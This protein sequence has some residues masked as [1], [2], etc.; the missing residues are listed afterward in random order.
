MNQD[1]RNSL[2][3]YFYLSFEQNKHGLDDIIK[4]IY[5]YYL[6]ER[7]DKVPMRNS[8]Y[9]SYILCFEII[10]SFFCDYEWHKVYDIL[11][12]IFEGTKS[13]VLRL[14]PDKYV[15]NIN[16][17][18]E[19]ENSAYRF[20]DGIVAPYI[21]E[22]EI[23]EVEEAINE[24][25]DKGIKTHLH[26]ALLKLSDKQNPDYRNS[27]KESIS[28]VEVCIRKVTG[29]STLGSGL[30]TLERSGVS[31]PNQLKEGMIKFYAYTNNKEDGIRHVIMDEESN[32]GFSEAKYM[33]VT[34]S[35]FINYIKLKNSE[36]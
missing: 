10:E 19:K 32:C 30:K 20:I 2:Y 24:S 17:I 6:K 5:V 4:D 16:S 11:E 8:V 33:L 28:A 12:F 14:N 21:D 26:D 31:I 34:C 3:N 15:K 29:D 7:V 9:G 22:V 25:G 27:I 18:L 13:G 36:K 23:A 1:L 35:A